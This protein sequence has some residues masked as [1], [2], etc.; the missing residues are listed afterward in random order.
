MALLPLQLS[1]VSTA[2]QIRLLGEGITVVLGLVISYVAFRG[3]RRNRSRPM[4]FVSA[5][6]LCVAGLPG[7][8]FVAF[9]ILPLSQAVVS[10]VVQLVEI[11]GMASILY[12]LR[13][14]PTG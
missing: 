7:V 3:Y 12:G 1:D 9:V 10:N 14:D 8:L 6:F 2:Q 11:L 4:L 13:V 5:G